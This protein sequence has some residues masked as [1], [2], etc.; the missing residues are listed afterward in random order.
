MKLAN[1][2]LYILCISF[3]HNNIICTLT[4]SSGKTLMW[5]S[6]G[7]QKQKGT[8]KITLTSLNFI[9]NKLY[10][11]VNLSSKIYI[12]I[13]GNNKVKNIFLKRLK[14]LGFSLIIIQERLCI[15]YNGCKKKKTRR[16]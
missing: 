4:D 2:S 6:T 9:I 3:L 11:W 15:S 1:K 12:K 10:I 13:K 14:M 8:K 5:S 7:E 16:I